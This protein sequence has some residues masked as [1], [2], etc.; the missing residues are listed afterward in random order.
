VV[1]SDRTRGNGRKLKHRKFLLNTRKHFC[2]VRMTQ[3]WHRFSRE[4]VEYLSLEILK[5]HLETVLGHQLCGH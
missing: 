4:I 5:S 3:H 1:P 2:T